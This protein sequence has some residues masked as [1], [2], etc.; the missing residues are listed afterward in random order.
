MFE[1]YCGMVGLGG[2]HDED[3]RRHP[4]Q[5]ANSISTVRVSTLL[6]TVL[7]LPQRARYLTRYQTLSV[8]IVGLQ[9]TTFGETPLEAE[10]LVC[11]AVDI[12]T[13]T[14]MLDSSAASSY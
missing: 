3:L 5:S 4:D 6:S 11:V 9:A 7:A 10:P 13:T 14:T 8:V 1:E 2:E 12:T